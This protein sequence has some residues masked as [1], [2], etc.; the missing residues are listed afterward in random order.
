MVLHHLMGA[1]HRGRLH[2]AG[3]LLQQSPHPGI[4]PS[5][6]L[7]MTPAQ[8]LGAFAAKDRQRLIEVIAID[9]MQGHIQQESGFLQV[10]IRQTAALGATR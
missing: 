7:F 8:T 3:H 5:E 2:H 6:H 4:G 1:H 10:V 9:H